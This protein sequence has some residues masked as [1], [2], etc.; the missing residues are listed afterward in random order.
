MNVFLS[1][2]LGIVSLSGLWQFRCT[3]P[4]GEWFNGT[5]PGAVQ[6]DL[7]DAGII[8]DPFYG[9]NEKRVQWVGEKDWEYRRQFDVSEQDLAQTHMELVFEG[10][11]T[12]ATIFVNGHKVLRT[13][14]MFRTWRVDVKAFLHEGQNEIRVT[15]DSVF[16]ID[17]AKYLAEG[18]FVELRLYV[19]GQLLSENQFFPEFPNCYS[20]MPALPSITAEETSEGVTLHISSK[21]L[22]RGLMLYTGN[23]ED[24][25]EDNCLTVVPGYDYTANVKTRTDA[26]AF[27]AKLRFQSLNDIMQ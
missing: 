15:F 14:N 18:C 11:D 9:D 27:L 7:M 20:Y 16:K 10:I 6:T 4:E 5:V 8:E 2:I 25:F 3:S 21:S 19:K 26:E 1:L 12:Y 23:D 22:I 17:I 13:D 24:V